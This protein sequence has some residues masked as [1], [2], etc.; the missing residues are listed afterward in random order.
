M[1]ER[2]PQ[3]DQGQVM[4][5]QLLDFSSGGGGPHLPNAERYRGRE[6]WLRLEQ[7]GGRRVINYR[8]EIGKDW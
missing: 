3:P 4:G 1:L 6:L 5:G 2:I 7:D 8:W